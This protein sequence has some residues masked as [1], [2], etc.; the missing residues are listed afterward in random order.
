MVKYSDDALD[1]VF[2][3]LSD[4]TRRKVL[5]SLSGGPRPVTELA[6]P[7]GMSLPGFL[8]HLR[9]LEDAG[10]IERLKEGRVVRCTLTA[11]PLQDAAVWLSHYRKFWTERLD[12]LARFLYNQE[13]TQQ[14]Q[15]PRPRSDRRSRSSASSTQRRGRSGARSPS[16]KC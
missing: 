14:W 1:A 4:P 12:A 9:A 5:V 11:E 7:H 2:A 6:Q 13:E 10:L 16:R 8:K 3:A 15:T